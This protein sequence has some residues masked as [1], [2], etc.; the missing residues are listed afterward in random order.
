MI[1]IL[2]DKNVESHVTNEMMRSL[3]S[4]LS[5]LELKKNN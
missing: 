1:L 2:Y 3:K 4:D 5:D